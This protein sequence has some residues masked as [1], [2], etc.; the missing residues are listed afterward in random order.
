MNSSFIHH[1]QVENGTCFKKVWCYICLVYYSSTLLSKLLNSLSKVPTIHSFIS[2]SDT[3]W[4]LDRGSSWQG[5]PP[6]PVWA[7]V[8]KSCMVWLSPILYVYQPGFYLFTFNLV[9]LKSTPKDGLRVLFQVTFYCLKGFLK[10]RWQP[11]SIHICWSCVPCRNFLRQLVLDTWI[12]F[13][14]EHADSMSCIHRAG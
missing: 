1:L 11:C 9:S 2:L 4:G 13:L 12:L 3:S 10:T 6:K 5:S 14:Y 7:A 8:S